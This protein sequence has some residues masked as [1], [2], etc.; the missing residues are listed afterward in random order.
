MTVVVQKSQSVASVT[1]IK[2]VTTV[3]VAR[4]GIPGPQGLPG[5]GMNNLDPVLVGLQ[6]GTPGAEAGN[7]IDISAALKDF[8]GAPLS[9]SLVDVEILVTDSAADNEPSA[10]A[11][12][13]AASAPVGSV[14]AGSGTARL[15]MRTA[16]GAMSLKVSE[17]SA[18]NRYLWLKQAGNAR[19]WVRSLTGVLELVFS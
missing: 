17:A 8:A 5:T 10:T 18:G 15:V 12:L 9:S 13:S 7:A 2:A 3:E 1:V 14:L 4:V 19:L 6:W 11:T 16:A